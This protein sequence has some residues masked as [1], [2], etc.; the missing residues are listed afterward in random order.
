MQINRKVS[1]V[2]DDEDVV[3]QVHPFK[4]GQHV[5]RVYL[6]SVEA[7]RVY[8]AMSKFLNGEFEERFGND[9]AT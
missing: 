9:E 2:K 1:V 3:L 8:V 7:M 4:P 6:T 5:E